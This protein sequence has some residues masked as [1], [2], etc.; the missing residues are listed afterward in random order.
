MRVIVLTDSSPR[1][2]HF[3]R[4][5]CSSSNV[6]G[7]FTGAKSAN[8]STFNRIRRE[9]KSAE[10]ISKFI[11]KRFY[12]IQYRKYLHLLGTQQ[13]DAE[14]RHFDNSQALFKKE[15]GELETKVDPSIGSINSKVYIGQIASLRPDIIVV[16]GT[17]LIGKEL[18]KAAPLMLNLHTGLSPWYRGGSTNLWPFLFK[19]YGYFGVTIHIMHSS[20]DG[21]SIVY[22][23]IP[24]IDATDSF[25][26]IN[27]KAIVIGTE[28]MKAAINDYQNDKL[29][30]VDQTF[31]GKLFHNIDLHGYHIK[32]YIENQQD[33]FSMVNW[34]KIRY[35]VGLVLNTEVQDRLSVA[36]KSKLLSN[37]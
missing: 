23:G 20:I 2:Y 13:R 4:S 15:F 25:P 37:N 26:S 5:I 29:A 10:R 19:D 1:H 6:V 30:S 35:P 33:F 9:L 14:K 18:M 3:A 24:T 17:C 31:S 12:D 28:L 7:V 21:G 16:M 34:E 27:A 22:H 32:R 8:T 11:L 36:Q